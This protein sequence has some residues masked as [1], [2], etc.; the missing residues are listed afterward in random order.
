MHIWRDIVINLEPTWWGVL[1]HLFDFWNIFLFI[2][3]FLVLFEKFHNLYSFIDSTVDIFRCYHWLWN[4]VALLWNLKLHLKCSWCY[5]EEK[6]EH[7]I[8]YVCNFVSK[9]SWN[10]NTVIALCECSGGFSM[11]WF[12]IQQVLFRVSKTL[13]CTESFQSKPFCCMCKLFHALCGFMWFNVLS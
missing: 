4:I 13:N 1:N 10:I 11:L 5:F 2:L 3:L 7:F 6:T 9:M 12:S 8:L